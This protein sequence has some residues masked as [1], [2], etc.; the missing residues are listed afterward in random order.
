MVFMSIFNFLEPAVTIIA[1][2]I[3]M[4]RVL[5]VSVAKGATSVHAS[6][7]E[8]NKS[9][10]HS[11]QMRWNSKVLSEPRKEGDEELLTIHVDRTV[12][13]SSTVASAGDGASDFGEDK[14]YDGA[15]RQ[16]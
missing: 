1:Q 11:K 2:A 3:P 7:S 5:L 8:G 9:N 6:P 12:Q 15:L 4:F 13:I 10:M 16:H 14:M